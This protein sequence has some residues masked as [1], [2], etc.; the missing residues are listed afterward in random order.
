[1][2]RVSGSS[3]RNR[4]ECGKL[5]SKYS[6]KQAKKKSGGRRARRGEAGGRRVG[7]AREEMEDDKRNG[8]EDSTDGDG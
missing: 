5:V 6:T 1:M 7:T 8:K 4:V 2:K 3:S